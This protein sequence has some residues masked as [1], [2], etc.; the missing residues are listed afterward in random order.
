MVFQ[1]DMKWLARCV[2]KTP[3]QRPNY[4]ELRRWIQGEL[5]QAKHKPKSRNRVQPQS[6]SI[7]DIR[8]RA[9]MNNFNGNVRDR[10]AQNR[11]A[12]NRNRQGFQH[13]NTH[14]II[15]NPGQRPTSLNP[16][17][18]QRQRD[19]LQKGVNNINMTQRERQQINQY[20]QHQM[21]QSQAQFTHNQYHPQQQQMD[22]LQ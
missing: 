17:P 6:G 12:Q 16:H 10:L 4:D 21:P 18:N 5:L 13:G 8:D 22:E 20:Q 14:T 7:Q 1:D 19:M 9:R 3:N 2:D 11:M 15:V